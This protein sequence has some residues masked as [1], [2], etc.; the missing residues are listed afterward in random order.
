ML[1]LEDCVATVSETGLVFV[2]VMNLTSNPQRIHGNTHLGTVGTVP[3][4]DQAVPQ[5][6]DKPKPQTDV[7]T[8]QIDFVHKGFEE[9]DR[10]RSRR[11]TTGLGNSPQQDRNAKLLGFC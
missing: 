8:D 7:D 10:S 3:L 4:V 6:V 9:I 2:S 5:R 1:F 11:K